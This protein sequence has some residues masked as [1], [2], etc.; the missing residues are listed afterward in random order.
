MG[1]SEADF[2]DEA[3]GLL[4]DWTQA[5]FQPQS[6]VSSRLDLISERTRSM[7][8]MWMYYDRAQEA[9]RELASLE[10]DLTKIYEESMV[11]TFDPRNVFSFIELFH[12]RFFEIEERLDNL[13]LPPITEDRASSESAHWVRNPLLLVQV[14]KGMNAALRAPL[15]PGLAASLVNLHL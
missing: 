2:T 11:L 14:W 13:V 9:H 6:P 1:Q 5:Q 15:D 8:S 4:L 3:G 12:I 10:R 7:I